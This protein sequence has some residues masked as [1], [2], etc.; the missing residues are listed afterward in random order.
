LT[1][2]ALRP[3]VTNGGEAAYNFAR[4]SREFALTDAILSEVA[5][6]TLYVSGGRVA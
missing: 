6:S 4:N 2:F 5:S 3:Q 1:P